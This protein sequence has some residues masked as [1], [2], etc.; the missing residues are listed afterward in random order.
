MKAER[1]FALGV[2]LGVFGSMVPDVPSTV[3]MHRDNPDVRSWLYWSYL[4]F[5]IV[6]V[7]VIAEVIDNG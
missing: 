4:A 1:A 2:L 3:L 6:A 7:I 5:G